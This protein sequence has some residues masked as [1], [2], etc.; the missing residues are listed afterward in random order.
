M[1]TL[2]S[3]HINFSIEEPTSSSDDLGNETYQHESISL[4]GRWMGSLSEILGFE[5]VA[6]PRH[7]L[8][9]EEV[10]TASP[11]SPSSSGSS[12]FATCSSGFADSSGHN[13]DLMTSDESDDD[14]DS[15]LKM[16][17]GC[18]VVRHSTPKKRAKVAFEILN[19]SKITKPKLITPISLETPIS[20]PV[21]QMCMTCHK[22]PSIVLPGFCKL[23]KFCSIE[24]RKVRCRHC[25]LKAAIVLEGFSKYRSWCSWKC[26]R[27]ET[28]RLIE[29]ERSE[30]NAR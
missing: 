3:Q 15:I 25:G 5:D 23:K 10:K 26:Q 21:Q 22:K 8:T 4:L 11:S 30:R 28:K 12:S 13:G 9:R 14:S 17:K 29:Q 19:V 16:R 6:P 27:D 7:E 24:C 2:S 18:Q 20:R 1:F